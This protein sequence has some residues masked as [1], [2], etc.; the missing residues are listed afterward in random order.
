MKLNEK[1]KAAIK[2]DA[3]ENWENDLT[4]AAAAHIHGAGVV[5]KVGRKI[6]EWFDKAQINDVKSQIDADGAPSSQPAQW[7]FNLDTKKYEKV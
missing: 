2:K 3:A 5:L 4:L 7:K 1:E 6:A